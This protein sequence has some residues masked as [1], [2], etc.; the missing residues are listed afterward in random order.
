MTDR[1]ELLALAVRC[2]TEGPSKELAAHILLTCG[3]RVSCRDGVWMWSPKGTIS[4]HDILDC[5]QSLDA[6]V[7]LVPENNWWSLQTM[8]REISTAWVGPYNDPI[9]FKVKHNGQS[10]TPALAL[11]AASLRARAEAMT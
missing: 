10:A 8:R 5:T 2:E 9:G 3:H 6:A 7:T 1:A 11:C 4:W